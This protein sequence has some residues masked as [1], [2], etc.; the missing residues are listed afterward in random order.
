MTME[1]FIRYMNFA[2]LVLFFLCYS[3]QVVYVFIR[4]LKKDVVRGERPFHRYAVIISA[5]NESAVIGGLLQS[6]NSQK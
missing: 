3:Y 1:T 4:L 6:I 2:I 5:R